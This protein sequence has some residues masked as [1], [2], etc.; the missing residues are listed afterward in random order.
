M[1]LRYLDCS[2]GRLQRGG[3][4]WE[5]KGM[6][7]GHGCDKNWDAGWSSDNFMGHL[8]NKRRKTM[9]FKLKPAENSEETKLLISSWHFVFDGALADKAGDMLRDFKHHSGVSTNRTVWRS[10]AS[11]KGQNPGFN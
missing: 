8:F 7:K 3:P 10:W 5:W 2:P 4:S 9:P 1:H 11:P 6:V